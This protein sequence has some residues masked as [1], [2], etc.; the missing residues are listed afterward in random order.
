MLVFNQ[1]KDYRAVLGQRR[2]WVGFGE[3]GHLEPLRLLPGDDGYMTFAVPKQCFW[4]YIQPLSKE[5]NGKKG[6]FW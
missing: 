3:D 1:W 6:V 4:E 5:Q 2:Q